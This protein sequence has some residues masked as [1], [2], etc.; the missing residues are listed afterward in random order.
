[1]VNSTV[2]F[3]H[4]GHPSYASC[5]FQRSAANLLASVAAIGNLAARRDS[6]QPEMQ[7]TGRS[8]A[9]AG[10]FPRGRLCFLSAAIFKAT[11]AHFIAVSQ[12]LLGT[13]ILTAT[14]PV[15]RYAG[16]DQYA[17]RARSFV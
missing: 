3:G 9:T 12:F 2:A 8:V 6:D 4:M 17:L 1:M 14:L 10:G 11:A 5:N 13:F 15:G 7:A 16:T